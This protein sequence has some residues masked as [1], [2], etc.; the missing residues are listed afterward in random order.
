MKLIISALILILLLIFSSLA[1]APVDNA[2]IKYTLETQGTA[3]TTIVKDVPFKIKAEMK[4]TPNQPLNN[5]RNLLLYTKAEGFTD[6]PVIKS[7]SKG[8]WLPQAGNPDINRF[9]EGSNNLWQ[10]MFTAAHGT[11]DATKETFKTLF[12]IDVKTSSNGQ[13]GLAT[14]PES[15]VEGNIE[16]FN[17]LLP[18]DST[19]EIVPEISACGDS[20]VGYNDVNENGIRDN[21]EWIEACDGTAESGC[22]ENCQFIEVGYKV[23]PNSNCDFGSRNCQ[24]TEMTPEELLK[25]KLNALIDG[26]CYPN[27]VHP[28]AFNKAGN[29]NDADFKGNINDGGKFNFLAKITAALQKFLTSKIPI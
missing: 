21:D 19:L 27:C 4:V 13:I 24:L 26:Q 3:V 1:I 29:T 23:A 10:Y 7:V 8:N 22:I 16:L 14:E 25:A 18:P 5:V 28:N 11:V 17:I 6:N 20:V 12:V 9:V 2:E 15:K